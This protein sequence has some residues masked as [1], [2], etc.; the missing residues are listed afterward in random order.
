MWKTSG[1]CSLI[2]QTFFR[3]E[4]LIKETAFGLDARYK[5]QEVKGDSDV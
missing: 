3:K 1:D 5:I 4:S 2:N